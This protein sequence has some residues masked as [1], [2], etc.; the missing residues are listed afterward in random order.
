[1][2]GNLIEMKVLAGITLYNPNI[3]R[4]KENIDA[5]YSQVAEVVCVDNESDDFKQ[6]KQLLL[7]VKL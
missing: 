7:Y 2:D 6:I 5:I 4:L 3:D 1:M